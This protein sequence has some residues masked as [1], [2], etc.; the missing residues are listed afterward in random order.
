MLNLVGKLQFS[1]RMDI[2]KDVR[3]ICQKGITYILTA[4]VMVSCITKKHEENK[5]E[6][7]GELNFSLVEPSHSGIHF[8]NKITEGKRLNYFTYPNIYSGGGVAV[9]DLDNDGLADIYFSGNMVDNKLYKNKGNMQFEDVTDK[10]GVAALEVVRWTRGVTMV[11]INNDDLLDIYVSV[12]DPPGRSNNLLYVNQGDMVFKEMASDYGIDDDSNSVQSVFFDYDRDGD[13]DLYIS[14]YPPFNLYNS[15]Q[16]FK[17]KNENPSHAESDRLYRN[18]GNGKFVN[19]SEE[20]GILNYGLTLNASISDFNSDG[21]SDIYV[22]NDFNA[23]DFLYINQRNGT[24]K[25]ELEGYFPH[26]SNFGMGT[27]A[28]DFNNDGYMDLFQSDMMSDNNTG[29]KTNMSPMNPEIFD[30]AVASGLH[31]QY[32][33]NCLQLNNGDG[34]FSDIAEMAGV[35]Y[36]DWSWAPLFVDLN[37][38]GWKDLFVSNGMRKNVNNNDYLLF[39]SRLYAQKKITGENQYKLIKF[40]PENPV[41]NVVFA[42]TGKLGFKKGIGNWGLSFKGFT[43]GVAYADFDQDGDLD[44]VFNNQDAKASIFENKARQT[45]EGQNYFR[46]KLMGGP[47]NR[48][49]LGARISLTTEDGTTQTQELILSR[50][51]QSSMEPVVHFGLG[52]ME[53][54]TTIKII[55]PDGSGQVLENIRVNQEVV[56]Q[57]K[58]GLVR[59]NLLP[60]TIA[61]NKLF[62]S[63]EKVGIDYA[64][65]E[66]YFDDFVRESLLP[67]KMSQFGPAMAIGDVNGDGFEDIYIGGS[68]GQKASLQ[69]QL[70][71]GGFETM[72]QDDFEKD[73]EHED[74]GAVFFDADKDGDLDLYVVSGGNEE[75]VAS[76]YY[77]DRFYE[78]VN[79]VFY[80]KK[81]TIPTIL[82]SGSCVVPCD[83]D[84]DGDIDLFVGGRQVPGRYPSPASSTLLLN[85]SDKG[86]LT[87]R[88]VTMEMAPMLEDI[89]MVTS[90]IWMDVDND[91]SKDLVL[92]GE[93]MAVKVLKNLK[94]RFVDITESTGLADETGWWNTLA[95]GDFDNDGDLDLVGGNL[96][97]N[98]KY[99]A[100]H[101]QPFKVYAKDFDDNQTFDIVLGFYEEGKLYPLRG[102]ECSSNQMPFIKK[103]FKT[104]DAFAKASLMD[105]YGQDNLG[106]A[107]QYEAKNFASSY[108][109]NLGNGKF[110]TKPLPMLAQISSVNSIHVDDL[111]SDGH[112][113][114]LV[115]GN[116]L[117]SE[118]ETPRNDASYGVFMKGDGAGNFTAQFAH[119]SGLSVKGEV[120]HIVPVQLANTRKKSLVF[121]I[122]NKSMN[123]LTVND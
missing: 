2:G 84:K 70:K 94:D 43:H 40:I 103:K 90:A 96:G 119:E 19:V 44:M 77:N 63:L 98:Y 89:G 116:L 72:P 58:R 110:K 80:R 91:T 75:E 102:R 60:D 62:T 55:W 114:L 52:K 32:M 123:F 122:N 113:D 48:Y 33:R 118:V 115:A 46:L 30:E 73:K 117:G 27:D 51:Y 106:A 11:D 1:E 23:K 18:E 61:D 69:I 99:K 97:K 12:S 101:G 7:F 45:F 107:I 21:W 38:D 74:T 41:D 6:P 22:S 15:N 36:T 29:K 76:D 25:D 49:G 67:H 65:K 5:L 100:G 56:V 24:F 68:K 39:S 14:V 53:K 79:G 42:N 35:G 111:D 13:L 28:A 17:D 109:E 82:S 120:K 59:K 20:A 71:D 10:A 54:A 34:T 57:K 105:V 9:G 26:T 85:E 108:F 37:N 31:Y 3:M 112:L 95:Y 121:A 81:S 47:G 78:N 50:G 4:T 88:D 64:H 83:F 16:F 86:E 87:F 8:E 93:W 92:T 66:N 104:Y